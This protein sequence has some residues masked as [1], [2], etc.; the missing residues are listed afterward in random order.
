MVGEATEG[1]SRPCYGGTTFPMMQS[2]DHAAAERL[3]MAADPFQAGLLMMRQ[4]LLRRH[5][6]I[7]DEE[8]RIRLRAWLAER[9]GGDI[10]DGQGRRVTWPRQ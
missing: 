4:N 9:P 10:A 3:R 7:S 2:D 1:D 6:G 8:L 5:P